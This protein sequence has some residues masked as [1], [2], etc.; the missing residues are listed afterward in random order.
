VIC[1]IP[2]GRSQRVN[3]DSPYLTVPHR[4][5][6]TVIVPC[7][8]NTEKSKKKKRS[9]KTRTE[10]ETK[11]KDTKRGSERKCM[12]LREGTYFN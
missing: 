7:I 9:T 2:V 4:T 8:I 11:T 12:C 6:L 1:H 5:I 3:V 10:I